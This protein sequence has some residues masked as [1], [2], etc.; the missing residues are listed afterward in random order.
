MIW[1]EPYVFQTMM[2]TIYNT[3][4]ACQVAIGEPTDLLPLR[5]HTV[6]SYACN[7]PLSTGC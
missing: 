7:R 5:G 1:E 2:V 6:I 3:M 4:K